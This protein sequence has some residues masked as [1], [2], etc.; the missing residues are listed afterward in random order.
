MTIK[1]VLVVG[2]GTMGAGIAQLCAQREFDT[3]IADA[4]QD[5]ADLAKSRIDA[6]LAKRVAKGKISESDK[7]TVMSRITATGE[8]SA[9]KDADFIVESIVEDLEI[10]KKVFA[11]L[12]EFARPEVVIATNTTCQSS[13][14][15]ASLPAA[16]TNPMFDLPNER[17]HVLA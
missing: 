17:Q 10:K 8:L 6:G 13:R 9:A 12:D 11:Q 5:L 4:N 7:A 2:G 3:T 16:Q 15:Q 1:K 14:A